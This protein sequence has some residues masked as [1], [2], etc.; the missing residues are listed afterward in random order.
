[1]F[2]SEI[3]WDSRACTGDLGPDSCVC[4]PPTTLPESGSW[5][6]LPP[7]ARGPEGPCKGI[8]KIKVQYHPLSITFEGRAGWQLP[9]LQSACHGTHSA[10]N[11]AGKDVLS[12]LI[13]G[14]SWHT[15]CITLDSKPMGRRDAWFD[16]ISGQ[17]HKELVQW[18]VGRREARS[19]WAVWL[20]TNAVIR[21]ICRH[22]QSCTA[23]APD[24][25]VCAH[26]RSIHCP[27]D[28]S[29]K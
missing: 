23:G 10:G 12:T 6:V 11:P 8:G 2:V 17:V 4:S 25:C 18:L 13:P 24:A 19:Q 3:C 29:I 5:P 27:M 9:S 1:M 15:S 26:P 28:H 14:S 21:H 22:T 16:F 7:W 20:M